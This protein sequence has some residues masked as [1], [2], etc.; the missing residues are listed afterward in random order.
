MSVVHPQPAII[1][2]PRLRPGD[3]VAVCAPAGPVSE[4]KI[5]A[6]LEV[7]R[8]R[9]RVEV[10]P[11]LCARRGYLSG[12]DDERA[13]SINRYLR[14]PDIRALFVA[15]GGYGLLRILDRL[16]A[17]ALARDPIPL[18]GFSDVT[19][20][21]AWAAGRAGV[22]GVHGPVVSQLGH[23]AD[24]DVAWLFRLL[25]DPRPPGEL[26]WPLE[27][28]GRPFDDEVRGRLVGGN[29]CLLS[30]LA[31]TPHQVDARGAVMFIEEVGERP[32]RIDRYLTHLSLAGALT[33][34]R[35][36]V[37]GEFFGCEE[38]ADDG[39]A[40]DVPAAGEVVD[41]R[42]RALSLPGLAGAPFGHGRHNAALPYA[43]AC[44]LSP[45]GRLALAESGV[46]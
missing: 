41:E 42:L 33:G 38:G 18:V 45:E 15:R 23:L 14:D 27:R 19:A 22:G 9:Y 10:A 30:H 17:P 6:G 13:E 39:A 4:A 25:E 3:R 34:A 44:A 35:A 7:L 31:G 16:D 11:D 24:G 1:R 36:V 20:L 21:L 5:R 32:Y 26:A 29:L 37:A 40:S 28:V 2:P 12:S 43:A 46:T 8:A